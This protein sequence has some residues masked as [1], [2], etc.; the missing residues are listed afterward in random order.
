MV[1]AEVAQRRAAD[2]WFLERGLPAVLRPGAL[3]RRLWPRSAPALAA[4]AVFMANS[5]LVV[6]ISG[7][8]T[9]DING[10]PTRTEWF[11]LGLLVLVAAGGGGG[12]LARFT[13]HQRARPHP[14]GL[15]FRRRGVRRGRSRRPEPPSGHE[16]RGRGHRG[17]RR[18]GAH[19]VRSGIHPGL[20][21]AHRH[22]QPGVH[23]R[24]VCPRAARCA[25][26]RP[27]VLQHL[28][29]VDGV[30]HQPAPAVAG[31]DVSRSDRYRVRHLGDGRQG[32]ADSVWFPPVLRRRR[33]ADRHA[34][35]D[36]ARPRIR[37]SVVTSGALA[38]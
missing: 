3:V 18:A 2:A 30:D 8:H 36:D 11:V 24:A 31:P 23:R 32:A 12:R 17:R 37:L 14:G 22:G 13:H 6:A 19:R 4:F 27:G 10:E 34:V 15:R 38:M 7:K 25:A 21:A 16:S 29:V 1:S 28:C 9:I 5:I 26:H 33:P 20:G 35:R